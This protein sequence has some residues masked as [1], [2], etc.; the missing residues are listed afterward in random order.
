MN[1]SL[2]EIINSFQNYWKKL[3]KPQRIVLIAAPLLVAT[4]LFSLI[5]WASRPNYVALFTKLDVGSAG[6]ITEKLKELKVEY[7]LADGGSTILVPEKDVAEARLQLANAGLPKEST[8]SFENLDQMRLGETDKD[9]RLRYILGLQNELEKTI[10][11]LE[12]VEYA[13]VH[14]VLP[15]PSLFADNQ[16][17]TTAAVTIKRALGAEMSEEQVRSIANLLAHSVEGL[18]VDK[19]TIVDTNGNTLSDFLGNS[20]SPHR[21]TANQMQIQQALENNIQLSVQSMLDKVFGP[22]KTVVRAN[23]VLNFDQKTITSQRSENGALVSRQETTETSVNQTPPGG[24]PGT[25]AN[26]PGGEA[27]GYLFNGQGSNSSSERTSI[28]E[29]Y[30]PSVIQEETVVSPGQIERLTVSVL[31]DAD[32]VTEEQ[33]AN[34]EAIVA[35]ATGINEERGDLIQVARLPFNKTSLLEDRAA[36]E[37]AAKKEQIIF[38]AQI[39]AAVAAGIIFLILLLRFRPRRKY[40]LQPLTPDGQK[41][42]TLEEAEQILAAQLEAER[43]AELKLARKKVKS[44]EEIEKE[45][46]RQEVEKYVKENPDDVARLVKTWLA[47]E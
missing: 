41:L 2:A 40:E 1:F 38:Y 27:P 11:T 8:F 9:R 44:S 47:E 25:E 18:K 14:I 3:T 36:L 45:K 6:A 39:G 29:N 19:V 30:Q 43:Q 23:A 15:E 37:K 7:K 21:L 26:V 46:I 28:T 20:T 4:A 13:R 31:A 16:N 24:V 12:G 33:L 17:E 32:S 34:I 5:Y 10:A 42:V 22:G 35:S